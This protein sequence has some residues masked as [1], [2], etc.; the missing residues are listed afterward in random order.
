MYQLEIDGKML[1]AKYENVGDV[2]PWFD[3]AI[4]R[5]AG[6]VVLWLHLIHGSHVIAMFPSAASQEIGGRPYPLPAA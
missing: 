3:I 6:S 1:D 2:T 5:G 4:A